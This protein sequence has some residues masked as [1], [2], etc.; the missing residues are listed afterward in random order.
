MQCGE[1][2]IELP[3]ENTVGLCE[4]CT[5]ELLEKIKKD[6]EKFKE[7]MKRLYPDVKIFHA[8]KL[9]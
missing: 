2:G 1:C 4:K 3:E 8:D 9:L 6:P 5:N 7:E